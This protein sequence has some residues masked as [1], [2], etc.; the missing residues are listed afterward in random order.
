[1]ILHK[2][3]VEK[4]CVIHGKNP[5]A[6]T[7]TAVGEFCR[8]VRICEG[9]D[10][11]VYDFEPIE[12]FDGRVFIC[13]DDEQLKPYGL[14]VPRETFREDAFYIKISGNI[15]VIDGG[16]LGKL[17]GVYEFLER[18]FGVRYY[19]YKDTRTPHTADIIAE[20]TE[21]NFTPGI[22][23]RDLYGHDSRYDA[24]IRSRFRST[25]ETDP[26]SMANYGV[27]TLWA[28]PSCHTVDRI[29]LQHDDPEYGYDKHPEYFSYLPKYGKR[30]FRLHND[31]GFPYGDGEICWSNKEVRAI[32]TERVKNWIID[33]PKARIFAI[34]QNDYNCYCECPECTALAKKYGKNGELRWSAPVVDA[35]N[36]IAR[37][38]KEWQKTDERV[39]DREIII[40]TFGYLYG[41]QAPIGIKAEDNLM[42]RLC[43]NP[44]Y[45]H[46]IEDET[47]AYNVD[48]KTIIDEW[49]EVTHKLW[50][51][52]YPGNFYWYTNYVPSLKTM[53]NH[54]KFWNDSGIEGL[55]MEFFDEPNYIGPF[56]EVRQYL[57]AR[58]MYNPDFDFKAELKMVME[59]F[60]GN[61]APF[62]LEFIKRYD[63]NCEKVEWQHYYCSETYYKECYTDEFI[64]VGTSLFETAL[65]QADNARVR[66]AVR[67]EYAFFKF[68]KM[69]VSTR[70]K[71]YGAMQEVLDEFKDL[72]INF[73]ML[74]RFVD[75][76]YG[77]EVTDW[78][79]PEIEKRN[80]NNMK[81]HISELAEKYGVKK[82][83]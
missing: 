9:S 14:T 83:D 74:D 38:I 6:I 16:R 36:D 13:P 41:R 68:L 73:Q 8:Q 25:A 44:C 70:G 40:E 53:Q 48:F 57:Y 49:K 71:D 47:C 79:R 29:L 1:M 11:K 33:S 18:Y 72:E 62:M 59:Y 27:E 30:I 22:R 82:D 31:L 24:R 80:L 67:R 51:W 3:R 60:Y 4:Y 77:G 58:C 69:Y 65:K 78:F 28:T 75:N 15:A 64:E 66:A 39:K 46:F 10:L 34:D 5:D 20:D 2:N 61:C 81:A 21:I 35:V 76:Y 52:S 50:I 55:F 37:R 23:Y 7:C 45:H 26:L 43:T 32:I 42:I 54:M 19:T 56:Y 12:H 63:E 17:Y